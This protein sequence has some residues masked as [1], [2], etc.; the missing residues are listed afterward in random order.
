MKSLPKSKTVVSLLLLGLAAI[1]VGGFTV[2]YFTDEAD[3]NKTFAAGTVRV[4][5]S[6]DGATGDGETEE[7]KFSTFAVDDLHV[8]PGECGVINWTIVNEGTEDARLRVHL[9]EDW[10]LVGTA[11]G[12]GDP[13]YFLPPCNDK[14][15]MY[16]PTPDEDDGVWLYYKEDVPGTDNNPEEAGR[17][18]P[19]KLVYVF[20][21]A[22]MDN[23]YQEAEFSLSGKVEAIQAANDASTIDPDW[24]DGW[25][26][27]TA[28]DYGHPTGLVGEALANYNYFHGEGAG[29]NSP[30]WIANGNCGQTEDPEPDPE[31][32]TLTVEKQSNYGRVVGL[33]YRTADG[34]VSGGG[35]YTEG[36]EV[37]LTATPETV[38]ILYTPYT[39]SVRWQINTGSGWENTNLVTRVGSTNDYNFTM[40]GYDV[41]LRAVFYWD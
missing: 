11:E 9:E 16:D 2:A 30:C 35:E 27:I 38:Y 21:G 40:P 8:V 4:S 3:I 12:E 18:V 20:D 24:A 23:A 14:W 32:Y 10:T 34:T 26:A 5:V 28:P 1:I 15:V 36:E 33:S 31:K 19:L 25:E 22:E 6:E 37:T 41:E 13:F 17:S 39:P 7:G 29:T